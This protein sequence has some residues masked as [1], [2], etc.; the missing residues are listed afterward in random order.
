M[1]Y[2]GHSSSEQLD[3]LSRQPAGSGEPWSHIESC[4]QCRT[5]LEKYRKLNVKLDQLAANGVR[6]TSTMN[7]PDESIWLEVAAGTLSPEESLS[8]SSHAATCDACAKKLQ[9]AI[10]IFDPEVTEEEERILDSL[11]SFHREASAKLVK[12]N[13]VAARPVKQPKSDKKT[14]RRSFWRPFSYGFAGIA[15]LVIV[16][17]L[18]LGPITDNLLARGYT[19]KGTLEY[20]IAK[21]SP[22]KEGT[23][24]PGLSRE[25]PTSL[26]LADLLIK[27]RLALSPQNPRWLGEK[28]RLE[29]VEGDESSAMNT[30]EQAHALD[31]KSKHIAIDLASAYARTGSKDLLFKAEELL[32]SVLPFEKYNLDLLRRDQENLEAL[33]NL[34]I[35]Y[36][37]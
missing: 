25:R 17:F 1:L 18:S 13:A 28:G 5:T 30:L 29:L 7:C 4:V 6:S 12:E 8:Y 10:R 14:L 19:Q 27:F 36:E 23:R 35:V 31:S 9:A 33:Y 15:A 26:V 24:G 16:G 21:A 32:L 34:A 20:R 3:Q 37:L 11:P 2:N 22:P